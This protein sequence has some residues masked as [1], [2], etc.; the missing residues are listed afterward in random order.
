MVLAKVPAPANILGLVM[1]GP[2]VITHGND[3]Q[4]HRFLSPILVGDEVWCQGFSEPD[5]GSDLASIQTRG[6]MVP[7]G[8]RIRGQKVWTSFAHRAKWCM[9]L[10]R[11]GDE[12][13]Y[14]NLTYFILDMR[15]PGVS[16]R[17]LRQ[18]TGDSEFNEVFFD[19]AFVPDSNVIGA[20]GAGWNIALT[21]LMFE[22]HGLGVASALDIKLALD[23]LAALIRARGLQ[24]DASVRRRFGALVVNTEA[25][26]LNG[27]RGL[28]RET[29]GVPGPEGSMVKIQW[30]TI[31][32]SLTELAIDVLGEDAIA[33]DPVWTQ[34]MLRARGNSIEGGT[35]EIQRNI[36]AERVLGLP[37]L[38]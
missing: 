25:M 6:E 32:Q 33:V 8:W 37:R 36:L 10:A 17:P 22:R 1:G 14:R 15:Q 18:I 2:V 3:E 13:R 7:G 27:Y 23:E 4:K 30:A 24:R 28:T 31:N 20:P 12:Q 35:S 38:R 29:D 21:T 26:R 16:V 5:S 19:S 11:T 9:L 34:R